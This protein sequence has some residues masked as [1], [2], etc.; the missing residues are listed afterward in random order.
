MYALEHF[1]ESSRRTGSI[2]PISTSSFMPNESVFLSAIFSNS[3]HLIGLSLRAKSFLEFPVLESFIKRH[4]RLSFNFA[5][6]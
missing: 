1:G 5:G 3:L 4:N 2:N 6:I